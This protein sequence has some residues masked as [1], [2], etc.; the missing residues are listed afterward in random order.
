VSD[1][2]IGIGPEPVPLIAEVLNAQSIWR[3]LSKPA[4]AAI[5]AATKE[6]ILVYAH[7]LTIKSLERHGFVVGTAYSSRTAVLTDAGRAV[8]KWNVKAKP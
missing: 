5:E 7:P 3:M 1:W 8:A 4:R 6:N 2:K